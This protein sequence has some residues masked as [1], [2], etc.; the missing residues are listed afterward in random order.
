[1]PVQREPETKKDPLEMHTSHETENLFDP[2]R[3]FTLLQSL[4]YNC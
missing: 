1:M 4:L 3:I 2:Q